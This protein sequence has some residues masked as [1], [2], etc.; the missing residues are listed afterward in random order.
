MPLAVAILMLSAPALATDVARRLAGAWPDPQATRALSPLPAGL[1]WPRNVLVVGTDSRER[2]R[3]HVGDVFG[4]AGT[5]SGE[6][7][8][9]VM[10]VRV[11]PE[12]ETRVLSIPRDVLADV[13]GYGPQRLST[14]L[15]YGGPALLIRTVRALTSLPIHHYVDIDF[16]AFAQMVDRVGGVEVESETAARDLYSGLELQPGRQRI[17]GWMT[18]ALVRARNTQEWRN[19]EWVAART[20]DLGRVARQQHVA[21]ALSSQMRGRAWPVLKEAAALGRAGR[22]VR[23]DSR[24]LLPDGLVLLRAFLDA[25]PAQFDI[26]PSEPALPEAD[27]SSPFSPHHLGTLNYQRVVE[28]AARRSLES[29]AR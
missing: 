1:P 4:P 15:E 25:T 5:L 10:L 19:G 16:L 12:D 2:F 9:V 20:G 18:L 7:A 14:A 28:P 23:V 22:H 21:T 6:R 13:D 8:D 11:D 27:R 17:D 24:L 3:D 29:F 26:L